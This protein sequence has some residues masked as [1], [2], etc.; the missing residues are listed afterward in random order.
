MI[1]YHGSSTG[2]IEALKPFVSN[3]ENP[4]VYLTNSQVLA[5]L[6]AAN[7]MKRPNGWFPYWWD[8]GE[9]LV[10]DEYYE[11]QLEEIYRGKTGYVYTCQGEYP[12]LPKMPWV[13]LSETDVPVI[14]C[15]VIPDL[16]EQLLQYEAEGRLVIRRWEQR[17]PAG[18]AGILKVVSDSLRDHEAHTHQAEEYRCFVY[19]RFPELRPGA[20]HP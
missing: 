17:T 3:H 20:G 2:G 18:R 12:T 1:L 19:A 4:Y 15:Q 8:R 16:Y 9:Q 13:Y 10:Y 7:P 6:Y 11:H 5:T 14:H